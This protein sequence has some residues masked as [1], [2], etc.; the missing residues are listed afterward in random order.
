MPTSTRIASSRT[1]H[2]TLALTLACATASS[3]S[4]DRAGG[5]VG[6]ECASA[7]IAVEG[8]NLTSTLG[9]TPSADPPAAEECTFLG[10]GAT[11]KDVWFRYEAPSQGLLNLDFCGSNFDTSVVV[12]RG[13]C[14]FLERIACDDDSCQ[15]GGPIYQSRI[16]DL[17]VNAGTHFIR[18]GGWGSVAGA[19][20]LQLG[21]TSID[22]GVGRFGIGY[23]TP[24]GLIAASL[25]AGGFHVIALR[26]DGS[27]ACWGSNSW[28]QCNVPSGLLPVRAVDAGWQH[29][30]VVQGD[31]RVRCWGSNS[32]GQCNVPALSGVSN[33]A[34]GGYH[35][36]ALKFDGSLIC[37]GLNAAGQCSV[38]AG[39][40][41]AMQVESGTWHN[42]T[43]L[44]DG[45]VR[46]WGDNGW[47]QCSVPSGLPL[48]TA[49]EAGSVH[50]V[51]LGVDGVVRAWGDNTFGQCATRAGVELIAGGNSNTMARMLDGS[52]ECWGYGDDGQTALPSGLRD[53][54]AIAVGAGG[55]WVISSTDCDE[56]DVSDVSEISQMDCDGNGEHD[57]WDAEQ[58]HIEDCNGNGFG[59]ACE[60]QLHV[61]ADSGHIG[62][63]GAAHYV[64]WIVEN[65]VPALE[66]DLVEVRIWG[67]GDF[68]G[69]LEYVR[70]RIGDTF[71][72]QALGATED[73]GETTPVELFTLSAAD[74]N[75]AIAGDGGLRVRLEPSIAVDWELCPNGTWV[76]VE[77]H[78]L[79]AQSSDCNLN[80]VLDGCE[81]ADGLSPDANGNGVPDACDAPFVACPTDFDGD[82]QTGASDI[83]L[84]L[85][86]WGSSNALYDLDA[87]GVIGASDLSLVLAYWG[88][89]L[90]Q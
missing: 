54:S 81:I 49:V 1:A 53:V 27:V 13:G 55:S 31:H 71:D 29:S 36:V 40:G 78:Y 66:P 15:P 7:L 8:L 2:L 5:L 37:W 64:T 33:I 56:N 19:V 79:G 34:A 22:A 28:G 84:M 88:A 61:F 44:S 39:I 25:S 41:A 80:G 76:N 12:Y 72:E 23:F 62:P 51:A 52:V 57:C 59:D 77:L 42:I 75:A 4:A 86:Y 89:C 48:C 18:V 69:G 67:R 43:L 63:I 85:A 90:P 47:G 68:S 14:G 3:A 20:Q 45:S 74:F 82:H 24:A 50:S 17:A 65:A 38:P 11:T 87:D 70:V 10:W 21:F 58:G 73:C 16:S 35:T 6:D 60:K 83:S 30:A 26:D 32:H 9:M 46:C